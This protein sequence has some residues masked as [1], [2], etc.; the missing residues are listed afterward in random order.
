[1]KRWILL[2]ALLLILSGLAIAQNEPKQGDE[3]YVKT[4]LEN[5]RVSPN[6]TLITQLPQATKV[7]VLEGREG[8]WIQVA[9]VGWIWSPSLVENQNKIDGFTMRVSHILVK[10]EEEAKELKRLLDNGKD[11]A[12]LAKE[13]STDTVTQAKGG[14]LGIIHKGDLMP[15]IDNELKKL[16]P[17]EISG[18]VKSPLGY[19]V[20]KRIE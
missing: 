14:D 19:H 9:I 17:G 8:K 15:E 1:M 7:T 6:G 2:T 3:L 16:K 11:F 20:F 18:V 10:T 4:P 5:L 12:T 13:R